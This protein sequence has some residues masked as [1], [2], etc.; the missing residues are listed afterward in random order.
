MAMNEN[1]ENCFSNSPVWATIVAT[2]G[3][4]EEKCVVSHTHY[5]FLAS[6]EHPKLHWN[7]IIFF[8]GNQLIVGQFATKNIDKFIQNWIKIGLIMP[9]E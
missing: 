5:A 6:I 4:F 9:L 3:E 7:V 1:P 2:D 8:I